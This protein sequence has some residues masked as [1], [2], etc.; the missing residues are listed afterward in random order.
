M[1]LKQYLALDGALSRNE[2]CEKLNISGGRLSQLNDAIA[3]GEG[4]WPADL[5]L[6]IEEATGGALD[7]STLSSIIARA[8]KAAA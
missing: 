6:K 8:R 7:A 3:G 4:E 1:T 5:A 2:L